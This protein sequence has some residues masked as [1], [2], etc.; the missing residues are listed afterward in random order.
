MLVA[1]CA[2]FWQKVP[3]KKE[4]DSLH[5]E[6]PRCGDSGFQSFRVT[7]DRETEVSATPDNDI[8]EDRVLAFPLQVIRGRSRAVMCVDSGPHHDELIGIWIGQ[9]RQ[10][11]CINDTE[12]RG[13]CPDSEREREHC[14]QSETGA[15][16]EHAESKAQVS[17]KKFKKRQAPP[18]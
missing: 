15:F 6:K 12:N 2:F 17:Q 11:R 8:L 4:V 7:V 14:D 16:S 13:I 18:V 10:N 9:G 3:P 1:H 5:P